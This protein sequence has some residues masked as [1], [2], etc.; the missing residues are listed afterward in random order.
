MR[1]VGRRRREA[2]QAFYV[3]KVRVWG[4]R[5]VRGRNYSMKREETAGRR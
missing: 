3:R 1:E 2:A 5:E 4:K